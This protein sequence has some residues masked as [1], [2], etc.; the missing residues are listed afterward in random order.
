MDAMYHHWFD[1]FHTQVVWANRPFTSL[2]EVHEG[3]YDAGAQGLPSDEMA[4][5]ALR[6]VNTDRAR[7]TTLEEEGWVVQTGFFHL[8]V[9]ETHRSS[10]AELTTSWW[11][12]IMI[13]EV[14]G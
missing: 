5:K 10:G 13:R 1:I 4:E 2:E 3:G 9:W 11:S 8:S 7:L 14:S 6:R 12:V